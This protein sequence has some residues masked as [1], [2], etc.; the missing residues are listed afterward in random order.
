MLDQKSLAVRALQIAGASSG[1]IYTVEALA[2][3]CR[4]RFGDDPKLLA[5]ALA[6]MMKG[7][8]KGMKRSSQTLPAQATLFDIAETIVFSTPLGDRA[9][10]GDDATTEESQAW[11]KEAQ[12]W[13]SQQANYFERWNANLL[14]AIESG[15]LDPKR[16][17]RQ[18]VRALTAKRGPR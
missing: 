1:G 7:A 9:V 4:E 5:E 6:G 12:Q 3:A 13:H 8:A 16:N 10:S 18:Q 14:A 2:Q 11:G 17:H 15:D